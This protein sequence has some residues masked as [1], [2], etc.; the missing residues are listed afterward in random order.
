MRR[1]L[2]AD[3]TLSEEAVRLRSHAP[4]AWDDFLAALD[5]YYRDAAEKTVSASPASLPNAQGRA[6]ALR[7]LVGTLAQAPETVQRMKG[8]Q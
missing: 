2:S 4:Q 3:E 1:E 5:A 7:A 6:Q 8:T